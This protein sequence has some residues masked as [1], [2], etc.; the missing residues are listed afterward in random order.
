MVKC[1]DGACLLGWSLITIED[2]EDGAKGNQDQAGLIFQGRSVCEE[3]KIESGEKGRRKG[4]QDQ[5]EEDG[6]SL[7]K[8]KEPEGDE[9]SPVPSS[10][11]SRLTR[12]RQPNLDLNEPV[13]VPRWGKQGRPQRRRA[14]RKERP[15]PMPV[16]TPT[17]AALTG[18]ADLRAPVDGMGWPVCLV[19]SGLV[20]RRS[21]R[22]ET[23]TCNDSEQGPRKQKT[24]GT[25]REARLGSGTSSAG[26]CR[27]HTLYTHYRVHSPG[28]GMHRDCTP[29]LHSHDFLTPGT[30]AVKL[31]KEPCLVS[32]VRVCTE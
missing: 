12:K 4:R 16:T 9:M 20:S 23:A 3:M 17:P 10:P 22:C 21:R 11:L 7:F 26:T 32:V 5:R 19:G 2:L 27:S 13:P 18:R 28:P 25:G 14:P 6:Y 15:M 8:G 24:W 29:R 31:D 1:S 30:P